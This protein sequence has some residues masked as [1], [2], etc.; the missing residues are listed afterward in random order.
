MARALRRHSSS[1]DRSLD[2]S[3]LVEKAETHAVARPSRAKRSLAWLQ[4]I[5]FLLGA[6]LLVWLIRS[7][8]VEPIF[9][10][11]GRVGFGF[12]IVVAANGTRH[13]LPTIAMRLSV[14]AE[15]RRFSL[16]Q[17]CP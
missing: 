4:A 7:I 13:F 10:A 16:A 6:L 8:G 15:P 3:A 17:A 2:Y 9:S 14:P 5:A 12:F 1:M 11:L